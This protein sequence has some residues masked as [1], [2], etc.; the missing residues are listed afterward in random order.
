VKQV[1]FVQGAG[2][3]THDEWDNHLVDSLKRQLGSGYDVRYPR[4]PNEADPTYAQWRDALVR[5]LAALRE[6]AIIVGHSIGAAFVVH[7]LADDPPPRKPA[8]IFL[9]APP[10]IGLG[11]WRNDD[12][13]AKT[14]LGSLLPRGAPVFLYHGTQDDIVP[15]AHVDLYRH[16]IPQATVRRLH[17]R[18]HQLNND[19]AEIAADI[20]A[21]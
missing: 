15:L 4:M 3:G 14:E 8:G 16:A 17:G 2:T 5:E 6:G 20:R 19:L 13:P 18:D 10:F 12:I 9:V 11:G 21:L 7:A 1:L